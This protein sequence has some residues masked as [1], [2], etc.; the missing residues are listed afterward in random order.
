MFKIRVNGRDINFVNRVKELEKL[1]ELAT[2]GSPLVEFVY[3]P[4]GC[5]KTT[6]MKYFVHSI[7]NDKNYTVIYI[8]AV[9]VSD[10]EKA[11]YTNINMTVKEIL[12][13]IT[14]TFNIPLGGL[15]ALNL[16]K[17]LSYIINKFKILNKNIVIIVDDVVRSIGLDKVEYY[18]KY[19]YE[20]GTKIKRE[21]EPRSLLILA[22]TSEGVS[23][24]LIAKHRYAVIHL[25]WN[26][27]KKSTEELVEQLSNRNIIEDVWELTG[28]N[29]A[30]IIELVVRFNSNIKKWLSKL[31]EKIIDIVHV[32]RLKSLIKYLR[33][34]VEN[35]DLLYESYDEGYLKILE[36]LEENNLVI[37]K[38]YS[39][40]SED[41]VNPDPT[42]GIGR[43]YAWQIPA[44]VIILRKLLSKS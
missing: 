40:L 23:R 35:V 11:I 18:V 24:R 39:T 5:G 41:Y 4:E 7:K 30:R 16:S 29:P 8:D 26:L 9:E 21:H 14:E 44:Y 19:L 27:D 38:G 43:Y 3:G 31:E 10:P 12:N 37:Y 6:L 34:V 13:T 42:L 17:I 32:V 22:T 15:I 36:I 1:R 33:D 25:L 2:K 28:G 20:L